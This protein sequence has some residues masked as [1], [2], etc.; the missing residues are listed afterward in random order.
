MT[1]DRSPTLLQE[2]AQDIVRI[3]LELVIASTDQHIV[4][5][6]AATTAM[7]IPIVMVYGS[8]TRLAE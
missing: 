3:K 4:V 5:A 6:R 7:S 8:Q 2:L 1:D